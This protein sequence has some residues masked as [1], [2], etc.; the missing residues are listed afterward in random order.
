MYDIY[1]VDKTVS[2]VPFRRFWAGRGWVLIF[3]HEQVEDLYSSVFLN[4]MV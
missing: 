2:G 4:M 3:P 1:L